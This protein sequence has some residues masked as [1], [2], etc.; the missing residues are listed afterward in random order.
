[1]PAAERGD[2]MPVF[3]DAFPLDR[4]IHIVVRGRVTIEEVRECVE[5]LKDPKIRGF[6]KLVDV[7]GG[8]ALMS[9]DEVRR[10][11]DSLRGPPDAPLRGPLAFLVG[12]DREGFAEVFAQTTQGDRPIALFESLHEARKWL[13]E[14]RDDRP[15]HS[16]R[17]SDGG[18]K[19]AGQS[20]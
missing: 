14:H 2:A 8:A 18:E 6:A 10:L 19:R 5:K 17:P 13:A 20:G 15:G 7:T 1:L 12:S 11:G 9:G 3:V 4:V 16:L